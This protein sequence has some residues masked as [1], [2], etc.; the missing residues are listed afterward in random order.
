[1]KINIPHK[2]DKEKSLLIDALRLLAWEQFKID[3]KSENPDSKLS[4]LEFYKTEFEPEWLNYK[5]HSMNLQQVKD[6]AKSLGYTPAELMTLRS[7]T[8]ANRQIAKTLSET[9]TVA[10]TVVEVEDLSKPLPY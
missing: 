8:Y 4:G 7:E 3:F 6:E 2:T 5:V 10:E 1:M 9:K